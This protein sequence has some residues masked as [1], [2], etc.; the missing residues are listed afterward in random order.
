[1]SDLARSKLSSST[2]ELPVS[3]P[4]AMKNV[5]AMAPP[6]RSRSTRPSSAD[7]TPIFPEIL[8]PPSMPMNGRSG[9]RSASSRNRSSLPMSSPATASP[10]RSIMA[11]ASPEVEAWARW[12]TPKASLTKRSPR[13][14][15]EAASAGSFASSPARNRVFSSSATPPAGSSETSAATPSGSASGMKRT[16]SPSNSDSRAA[17]GARDSPGVG[18]SGRPK[19]ERR[20][21]L[22]P[23]SR[24]SSIVGTEERSRWSS[25]TRP[26]SKGTL[27]S[28]RT[29]AVRPLSHPASMSVMVFFMRSVRR[30]GGRG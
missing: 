14:A 28:A 22:A 13:A 29:T 18:P 20:T 10:P 4:I 27:K 21:T 19:C 26:A 3:S 2:S 16:G 17:T 30:I 9:S 25:V 23:A 11:R 1:M 5:L 24:R 12:A 8:E 7:M 15:H 6:I